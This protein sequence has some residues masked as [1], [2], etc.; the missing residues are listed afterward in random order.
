MRTFIYC[1]VLLITMSNKLHS[2]EQIK[3]GKWMISH[4][5]GGI[6]YES[7]SYV[8]YKNDELDDKRKNN[9]IGLDM[10]FQ[11]PTY[12]SMTAYRQKYQNSDDPNDDYRVSEFGIYLYPEIGRFVK[13]GLLVGAK[14]TL[15]YSV[16]KEKADDG[17][18]E[19]KGHEASYGVGPFIR[20]YFSEKKNGA[21]YIG[22]GASIVRNPFRSEGD[23]T[24]ADPYHSEQKGNVTVITAGP[25]AGYAWFLGKHW[26]I[27][28]QLEYR[29]HQEKYKETSKLFVDGVMAAD[30]PVHYRS[31]EKRSRVG[32]N[33]GVS[34]TF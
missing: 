2:Q 34:F 21:P 27:N 3:K 22:A 6:F 28:L 13:N 17:L 33:A 19:S 5:F 7:N 18:S 10:E 29:Y 11:S 31:T 26:S 25:Y 23:Y 9:W 12:A 1:I 15:G 8:R 24:F 4:S 14:L 32:L 16:G 20:Y 30:Y